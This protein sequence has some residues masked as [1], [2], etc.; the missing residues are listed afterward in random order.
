MH[1][2]VKQ[3]RGI[4]LFSRQRDPHAVI[5][6]VLIFALSL[7]SAQVMPCRKTLVYADFVHGSPVDSFKANATYCGELL[8]K[9]LPL[10]VPQRNATLQQGRALPCIRAAI[11]EKFYHTA[12]AVYGCRG[13]PAR[14]D[15]FATESAGRIPVS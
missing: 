11:P 10:T 13:L 1:E 9:R 12:C 3:P 4:D 15:R 14:R 8:T 6:P 7:V 2:V 5:V